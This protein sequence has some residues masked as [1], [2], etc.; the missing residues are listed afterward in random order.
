MLSSSKIK[1][2]MPPQAITEAMYGLHCPLKRTLKYK[3]VARGVE[4]TPVRKDVLFFR[5]N[6]GLRHTCVLIQCF[7]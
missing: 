7:T 1:G 6:A 3:G 4:I 5:R 2:E